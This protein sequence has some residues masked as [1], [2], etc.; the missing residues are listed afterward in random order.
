MIYHVLAW[1]AYAIPLPFL[2]YYTP[3]LSEREFQLGV[4]LGGITLIYG[5]A[6]FI[7]LGN[8]LLSL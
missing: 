5:I 1:V 4:M 3:R 7:L 6:Y 8:A 2:I